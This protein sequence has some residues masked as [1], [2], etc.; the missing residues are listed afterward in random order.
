VPLDQ[1]P[2]VLNNWDMVPPGCEGMSV[3]D[4][5][6]LGPSTPV[7]PMHKLAYTA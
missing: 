7:S 2:R 4:V 3:Q 1:R 5:K 6:A